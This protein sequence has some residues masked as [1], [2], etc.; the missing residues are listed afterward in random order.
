[1]RVLFVNHTGQVSGAEQAMLSL[2]HAIRDEVDVAIA[3]P[4]GPLTC[5]LRSAGF[6]V[7]AIPE[8]YGS[9]KLHPARTAAAVW[10]MARAAAAV[11]TV[12]KEARADVIHANSTRAGLICAAA[13]L[14]G[15]TPVITHVRDVLPRGGTP[16]LVRSVIGRRSAALVAISEHVF[17]TLPGRGA[18]LIYDCVD[19]SRF[20]PA[21]VSRERTRADLGLD[22]DVPVL[23]IVAQI[24]PWKGQDDAVKALAAV[25]TDAG[26]V[27]LLIV[28]SVK[29]VSRATRHDNPAYMRQLDSLI[30]ALGLREHVTFLGEREDIPE[31]IGAMDVLLLPSWEEPFGKAVVEGMAMQVPVVVT[32][33]GGPA[34]V[35]RDGVDGL[36][37]PPRQPEA[38]AR[39]ISE[40]IS[41]PDRR[42][43][44]GRRGRERACGRFGLEAH[45]RSVLSLYSAIVPAGR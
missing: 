13:T 23:G 21:L 19:C 38:W 9:L 26:P 11:R 34:E 10:E 36:V 18:H 37:V 40:L 7:D 41:A 33:I 14:A 20:D 15:G 45:A 22:R 2:L 39:A 43:E 4:A 27:R 12:L 29:F 5:A 16:A 17:R 35:V 8:T 3:C 25:K 6:K 42:L 31:L 30:D 32:S 24:T 44:M 28:G 1:M